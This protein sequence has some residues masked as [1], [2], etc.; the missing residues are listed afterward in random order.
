MPHNAEVIDGIA[1]EA[2]V[3]GK[4]V[5]LVAGGYDLCDTPGET[6]D[7][8]AFSDAAAGEAVGI[9]VGQIVMVKV[10]AA[11]VLDAAALT[12]DA[13]GLAITATAGDI[14]RCKAR[15]AGAAGAWVEAQWFDAYEFDGT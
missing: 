10:G 4:F 11:P 15:M 14:V 7:G 1:H 12:P 13:N 3:K 8:I 5:K 9:Q 2:L 6:A